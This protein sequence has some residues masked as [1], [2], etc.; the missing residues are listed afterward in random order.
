M[1]GVRTPLTRGNVAKTASQNYQ[2]SSQVD[3]FKVFEHHIALRQK[4]NDND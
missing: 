2:Q 1:V 4:R 3:C